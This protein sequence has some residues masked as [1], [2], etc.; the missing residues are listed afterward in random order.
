MTSSKFRS[1]KA[2]PSPRP[3]LARK[4][5]HVP[6]ANLLDQAVGTIQC[7]EVGLQRIDLDANGAKR[8][9]GLNQARRRQ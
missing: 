1:K 7:S 3:A 2:P 4:G 5:V 9:C 6:C 8:T